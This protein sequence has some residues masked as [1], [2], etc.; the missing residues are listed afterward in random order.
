MGLDCVLL[1][2]DGHMAAAVR[3]GDGYLLCETASDSIIQIGG[4]DLSRHGEDPV[5]RVPG[6]TS[7]TMLSL[8]GFVASYRNLIKRL[9]GA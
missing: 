9:V 7:G 3:D 1:D 4:T 5:I 8:D 6:E 2:Y